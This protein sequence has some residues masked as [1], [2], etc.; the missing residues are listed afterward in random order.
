MYNF[1]LLARVVLMQATV[2][3]LSQ[4]GRVTAVTLPND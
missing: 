1:L 4:R 3:L 2:A